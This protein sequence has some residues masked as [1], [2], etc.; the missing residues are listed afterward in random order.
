MHIVL[1]CITS[2]A[3]RWG[4]E[5]RPGLDTF[6]ILVG[7]LLRDLSK[8]RKGNKSEWKENKMNSDKKEK[9]T[10]REQVGKRTPPRFKVGRRS[11]L[12]CVKRNP[13]NSNHDI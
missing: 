6:P 10:E 3:V 2:E 1:L 8:G 13:I 7:T 4:V 12:I 5:C 11:Y 9:K